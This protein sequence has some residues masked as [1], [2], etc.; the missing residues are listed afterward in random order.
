[1]KK[2]V[3]GFDVFQVQT[4]QQVDM[5]LERFLISEVKFPFRRHV[6][7]AAT[8]TVGE[9]A[10]KRGDVINDEHVVQSQDSLIYSVHQKR[11]GLSVETDFNVLLCS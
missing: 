9:T 5:C 8:P 6:P 3:S 7:S 10:P 1:M 11:F 4:P 2:R